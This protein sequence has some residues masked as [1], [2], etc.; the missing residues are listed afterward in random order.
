MSLINILQS[1]GFYTDLASIEIDA[2]GDGVFDQSIVLK[3]L[4]E[5][6]VADYAT[7]L[8]ENDIRKIMSSLRN[9]LMNNDSF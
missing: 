5:N 6:D 9:S 8:S 2:D 3:R 4:S 1:M 7:K